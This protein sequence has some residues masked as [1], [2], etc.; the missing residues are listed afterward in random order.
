M[1]NY[2][3]CLLV[4]QER[5]WAATAERSYLTADSFV[6]LRKTGDAIRRAGDRAASNAMKRRLA[7][8]RLSLTAEASHG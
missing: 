4:Q 2:H 8:L 1:K 5:A 6:L 3:I 7:A